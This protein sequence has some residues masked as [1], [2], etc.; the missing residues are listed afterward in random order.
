ME[1]NRSRFY[2]NPT[3]D[4]PLGAAITD[5]TPKTGD[6]I[7]INSKRFKELVK[8]YGDIKIVSPKSGREITVGK[9][10]Y[11]QLLKEGLL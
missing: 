4:S 9:I 6:I 5:R 3:I 8:K 11:N 1:T 7:D 2:N 10:T